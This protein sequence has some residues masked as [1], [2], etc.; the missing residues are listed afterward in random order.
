MQHI[1]HSP[2]GK[3]GFLR[4]LSHLEMLM[5]RRLPATGLVPRAPAAFTG[6]SW[7]PPPLWP[8]LIGYGPV[9]YLVNRF[10]FGPG[11]AGLPNT[12]PLPPDAIFTPLFDGQP[13][14]R[15][16]SEPHTV[17]LPGMDWPPLEGYYAYEVK[18]VNLLAFVSKDGSRAS[19]RHY[20][21]LA[22]I[23]PRAR[24]SGEH[25]LVVE[26]ST[27]VVTAEID[28]DWDADED[29]ISPDV[30]DYRISANFKP[31]ETTSVQVTSIL[32]SDPLV[33]TD[34]R[35]FTGRNAK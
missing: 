34:K 19:V 31:L 1:R 9:C 17:D 6:L 14:L 15:P 26:E 28:I 20:D 4:L 35:Y 12:P 24:L 21:D 23:H 3:T 33:C 25:S 27:Q 11:S 7:S 18:G 16:S 29:F 30:I 13:L 5:G 8:R 10:D 32:S 2:P 22:P